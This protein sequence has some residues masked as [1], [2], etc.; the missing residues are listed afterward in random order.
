V[1][2]AEATASPKASA[3]E[4]SAAEATLAPSAPFRKAARHVPRPGQAREAAA[5]KARIGGELTETLLLHD[6]VPNIRHT[7]AA[8][9]KLREQSRNERT[10]HEFRGHS[11]EAVLFE[12]LANLFELRGALSMALVQRFVARGL[13]LEPRNFGTDRRELIDGSI[14]VGCR[15][16]VRTLA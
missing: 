2:T 1:R 9:E 8:A 12:A 16:P 14:V 10:V 6:R 4:A 13:V 7:E 5:A 11:I 3:A 15:S